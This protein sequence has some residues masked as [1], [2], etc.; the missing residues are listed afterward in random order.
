MVEAERYPTIREALQALKRGSCPTPPAE[1]ATGAV[2][3]SAEVWQ[4]VVAELREM[5]AE[6]GALPEGE[7][8]TATATGAAPGVL[9][10]VAMRLERRLRG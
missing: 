3:A 5:R 4:A 7:R 1:V 6:L 2:G 8:A 10:R 9:V